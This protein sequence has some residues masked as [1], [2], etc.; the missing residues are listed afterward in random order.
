MLKNDIRTRLERKTEELK[1]I[2]AEQ[3]QEARIPNERN[4]SK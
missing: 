3:K 4:E 1:P 2:I